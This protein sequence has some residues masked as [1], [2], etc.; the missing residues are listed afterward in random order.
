MSF[1]I[2]NPVFMSFIEFDQKYPNV[3]NLRDTHVEICMEDYVGPVEC[4]HE[5]VIRNFRQTGLLVASQPDHTGYYPLLIT[6]YE[7]VKEDDRRGF[8]QQLPD[9]NQ[10]IMKNFFDNVVDSEMNE[11]PCLDGSI[12]EI[13]DGIQCITNFPNT[14]NTMYYFVV[15]KF[16]NLPRNIHVVGY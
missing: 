11:H 2:Q 13:V 14:L 3:F 4:I 7:D 6:A 12:D 1:F 10:V 8:F 9:G 15:G 5:I 16:Y